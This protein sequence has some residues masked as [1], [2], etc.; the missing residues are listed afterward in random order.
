MVN[1]EQT[2]NLPVTP[3][4]LL[5]NDSQF[6]LSVEPDANYLT[7]PVYPHVPSGDA[8]SR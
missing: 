2:I 3:P 7:N 4:E 8:G 5:T 6:T 1:V